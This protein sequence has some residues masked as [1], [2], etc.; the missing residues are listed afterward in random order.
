MAITVTD[1][2]T[3]FTL[4]RLE[5]GYT[6]PSRNVL[7]EVPGRP[8]P[9]VV[10]FTP[11]TRA[12]QLQLLL[13]DVATAAACEVMHAEAGTLVATDPDDPTLPMSY[14]VSGDMSVTRD[15]GGTT[16]GLL[17]VPFREVLA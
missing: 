11:A 7:H 1:G 6:R 12:G 17:V 14:V 8:D 13:D 15:P 5:Q 10:R 3:P 16:R 2:V 4:H 9:E